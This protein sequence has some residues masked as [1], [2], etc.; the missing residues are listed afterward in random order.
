MMHRLLTKSSSAPTAILHRD[1]REPD[2]LL[3]PGR[4]FELEPVRL[5]LRMRIVKSEITTKFVAPS[6][7]QITL[8]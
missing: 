5:S 8:F 1:L 7:I 4:Q 6:R 3:T 2:V